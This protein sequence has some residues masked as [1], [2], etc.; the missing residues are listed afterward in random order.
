MAWR[1]REK[2]TRKRKRQQQQQ[3]HRKPECGMVANQSFNF[4]VDLHILEKQPR[5]KRRKRRRAMLNQQQQQ[6]RKSIL[7]CIHHQSLSN[8]LLRTIEAMEED[9]ASRGAAAR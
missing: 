9:A 3:Q 8:P 6:P 7:D 2:K 1:G 4:R 5:R